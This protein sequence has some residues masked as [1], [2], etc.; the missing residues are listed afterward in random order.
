VDLGYDQTLTG[1]IPAVQL[2]TLGHEGR[3]PPLVADNRVDPQTGTLLNDPVLDTA[4]IIR[5]RRVWDSWSTR[6]SRVP[7]TNR[8]LYPAGVTFPPSYPPPYPVPLRGLQIQIRVVDPTNQ[9]I[10]SHTIRM[11]FSNNL[12]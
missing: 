6:Y 11:D 4:S 10:K 7:P 12:D 9:K 5:L 3:I 8:S 1:T 2:G